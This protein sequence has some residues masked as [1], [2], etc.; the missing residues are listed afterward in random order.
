[1]GKL[2]KLQNIEEEL[3]RNVSVQLLNNRNSS[4]KI[5][6]LS[7][8]LQNVATRLCRE[9]CSKDPEHKCKPCPK[10]WI[11]H[12]DRCYLLR[13][14]YFTWEES[15]RFCSAQNAS[16]LTMRNKSEL[17]FIRSKQL[18]DHWLGLLPRRNYKHAEK[19]EDLVFPSAGE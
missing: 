11:W 10:S 12:K 17:E 16:L 5:R 3:Q 7:V 18:F 6:N 14:D 19:M 2:N 1:M 13:N 8:A 15:D 4:E 9:L